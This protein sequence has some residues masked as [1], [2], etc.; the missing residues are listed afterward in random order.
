MCKGFLFSKKNSSCIL[1][2][3]YA[4]LPDSHSHLARFRVSIAHGNGGDLG[5]A[6][7][8]VGYCAMVA[9]IRAQGNR[10]EGEVDD[11]R[12]KNSEGSH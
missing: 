9:G 2:P 10:L 1:V 4:T 12:N 3:T 8:G 11:A 5:A 7:G 6:F